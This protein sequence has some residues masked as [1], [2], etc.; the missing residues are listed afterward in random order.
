MKFHIQHWYF[1]LIETFSYLIIKRNHLELQELYQRARYSE[2]GKVRG[3]KLGAVDKY[4]IRRK[5]SL[6]R[7]IW[8]GESTSYTF[9]DKDRKVLIEAYQSNQYPNADTKKGLQLATGLDKKQIDNWFK[10]RRQRD[11]PHDQK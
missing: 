5:Y 2:A 10:N 7:T 4:R 8:D 3:R 11:R 9:K 1:Y 6:P